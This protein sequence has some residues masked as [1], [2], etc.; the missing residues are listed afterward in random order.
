MSENNILYVKGKINESSFDKS[1]YTDDH[2][3][4]CTCIGS[5]IIE[6]GDGYD[7]YA[8][9]DK[10]HIRWKFDTNKEYEIIIREV[11]EE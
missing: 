6:I 4:P 5:Q 9:K 7:E 2:D 8:S 3:V 1:F 11:K 10:D